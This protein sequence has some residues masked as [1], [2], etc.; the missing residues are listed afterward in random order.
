MNTI[1]TDGKWQEGTF[2]MT[3]FQIENYATKQTAGKVIGDL[4][5]SCLIADNAIKKAMREL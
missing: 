4:Y 2:F 1:D 5:D 3:R